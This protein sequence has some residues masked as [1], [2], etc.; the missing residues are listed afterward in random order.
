M[1]NL[2]SRERY[3]SYKYRDKLRESTQK[4]TGFK[5]KIISMIVKS[6]CSHVDSGVSRFG[7][8]I[9]DNLVE[10]CAFLGKKTLGFVVQKSEDLFVR[11]KGGI[12]GKISTFSCQKKRDEKAPQTG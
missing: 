4:V 10:I 9:P 8:K 11:K 2:F 3:F 5:R 7:K 6:Y 12:F 1:M